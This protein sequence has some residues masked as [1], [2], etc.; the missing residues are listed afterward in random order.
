MKKLYK[1]QENSKRK[2]SECKNEVG[3]Q[4]GYSAKKIENLK[5]NKTEIW[6]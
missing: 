2:F 1:L 6:S 3:E 4:K 5:K